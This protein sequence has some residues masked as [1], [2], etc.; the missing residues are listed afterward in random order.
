MLCL[1]IDGTQ[2]AS[3]STILSDGVNRPPSQAN[4]ASENVGARYT[5]ITGVPAPGRVYEH[6]FSRA[7]ATRFDIDLIGFWQKYLSPASQP[8]ATFRRLA[9]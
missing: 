8:P 4:E 3:P 5:T 6:G 1:G 2:L 9:N 7:A